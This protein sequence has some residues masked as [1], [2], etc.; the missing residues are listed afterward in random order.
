[1]TEYHKQCKLQK[2]NAHTTCWI[3]ENFAKMG[4][5]LKIE[6]DP[7][8]VVTFIGVRMESSKMMERS[9]DYLRQRK[10]SDI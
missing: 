9:R 1:M 4:K 3:P 7:G 2:G 6:E 10:H 8:W 5:V